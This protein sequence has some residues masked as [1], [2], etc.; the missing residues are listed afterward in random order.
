[1]KYPLYLILIFLNL[2]VSAQDFLSVGTEWNYRGVQLSW[3]PSYSNTRNWIAEETENY[4]VL[5]RQA[6]SCTYRPE[7]GYI[8][9][10]DGKIYYLDLFGEQLLYD[11]TAEVG[12]VVT[13]PFWWD[14]YEPI[15]SGPDTFYYE[16]DSISTI[17]FNFNELK[18]FHVTYSFDN[19]N[20]FLFNGMTGTIIE[21][22]GST[23]NFF[24]FPE[25]GSCDGFQIFGLNCWSHPEF[26]NMQLSDDPCGESTNTDHLETE[27]NSIQINPNPFE[28]QFEI[29]F[30]NSIRNPSIKLFST[31]GK[32]V[33]HRKF[34][35]DLDE[36]SVELSFLRK[37]LYIL[38]IYSEKGHVVKIE[39]VLKN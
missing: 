22:L 6:T 27:N 2:Q 7:T 31:D 4:K 21:N 30:D 26:G 28:K 3:P 34:Q 8:R 32:L 10:E 18:K 20:G 11:F 12:D 38:C 29:N 36:L 15:A 24:H 13:L 5:K 23:T 25:N 16:V 14:F 35:E 9:E 39:R 1:M 17:I 19:P 37:G 33:Y